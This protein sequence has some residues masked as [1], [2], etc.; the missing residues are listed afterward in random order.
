MD[1][2][3]I[4]LVSTGADRGGAAFV[5]PGQASREQGRRDRAA[6]RHESSRPITPFSKSSIAW[7]ISALVFMT[8]GP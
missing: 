2:I 4:R 6:C 5:A 8:N 1:R 3:G 7:P